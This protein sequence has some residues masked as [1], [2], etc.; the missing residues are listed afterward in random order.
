M[1]FLETSQ[2]PIKYIIASRRILYLQNILKRHEDEL[3]K[4]VYYAMRYSPLK[5]DWSNTVF[6]DMQS[7]G[8]N[9]SEEVISQMSKTAFKTIV[10]SKM[11]Q[12]VLKELNTI[13][14]GHNKVNCIQHSSLKVP[15]KYLTSNKFT[16]KQKSLLFNLRCT[17]QSEFLSNFSSSNQTI[18][19]KI[20]QGYEDSQE[21]AILCEKLRD[22]L[23]IM[24][25]QL[26]EQ[27]KYSDLCSNIHDQLRIT[28][29]YQLFIDAR[30]R[31]RDTPRVGLPGHS[32]G[33]RDVLQYMSLRNYIIIIQGVKNKLIVQH[34]A[35]FWPFLRAPAEN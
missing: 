14:L 20:C 19:C 4:R 26:L 18:P 16:N 31:I 10:K 2:L 15:Q 23:P 30:E 34:P 17:S 24:N 6:E 12:H 5:G 28:I 32:S 35:H 22:S 9:E 33:P 3:I 7:I 13:K 1:L 29:V 27:V 25:R 21:H 11:R 8:L